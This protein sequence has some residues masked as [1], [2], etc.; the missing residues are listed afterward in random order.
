M[1]MPAGVGLGIVG[2][3]L[4]AHAPWL[5]YRGNL[6]DSRRR[7]GERRLHAVAIGHDR[8]G[9][10]ASRQLDQEVATGGVQGREDRIDRGI[11]LYS[12][13][14]PP[15]EIIEAESAFDRS[16]PDG[17]IAPIGC[18]IGFDVEMNA[19]E[20]RGAQRLQPDEQLDVSRKTGWPKSPV[21]LSGHG[22]D[23]PAARL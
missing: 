20:Q 8:D 3:Y 23:A 5:L 12:R 14:M 7:P 22:I 19:V 2:V 4:N 17:G 21:G 11:D 10:H 6:R 1:T 9:I 18:S 15:D 16:R 13:R